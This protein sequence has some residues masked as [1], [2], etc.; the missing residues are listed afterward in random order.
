MARIRTIKPS[1]FRDEELQELEINNPGK[2]VM[3]VFA[4][5]WCHSDAQGIFEWKPKTLA[6][7]ILPFLE[8]EIKETLQLLLDAK[9]ITHYSVEGRNY[10]CVRTF[11]QHQRITGKEREE[12]KKFP[13]PSQGNNGETTGK[14]PVAQEKERNTGKERSVEKNPVVS[15][16]QK[17]HTF[18]NSPYFEKVVF[19][20]ALKKNSEKFPAGIDP[21]HYH[22]RASAGNYLYSDW[23]AAVATWANEDFENNCLNGKRKQRNTATHKPISKKPFSKL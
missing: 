15:Q 10:G 20:E 22:K 12:G 13:L 14:H 23:L 7:D 8:F 11:L 18:K 4:G 16:P 6:L 3:L 1:F 21:N 17:K 9:F 2:N 5:L 19:I